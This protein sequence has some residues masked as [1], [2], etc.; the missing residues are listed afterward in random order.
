LRNNKS[1]LREVKTRLVEWLVKGHTECTE[2][3]LSGQLTVYLSSRQLIHKTLLTRHLWPL[4]F[5]KLWQCYTSDID[6][7]VLFLFMPLEPLISLSRWCTMRSLALWGGIQDGQP[8]H[9]CLLMKAKS[10]SK[11]GAVIKSQE[12]L[13]T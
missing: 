2:G 5:L 3:S 13:Q 10:V 9:P 12:T 6:S 7:H 8:W 1:N 4:V 11:A